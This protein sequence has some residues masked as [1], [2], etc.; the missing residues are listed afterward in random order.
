MKPSEVA[1]LLVV[2]AGL[3]RYASAANQSTDKAVAWAAALNVKASALTFAEARQLVVEH[4]AESDESLTPYA[5][6]EAWNRKHRRLPAQIAADVRSAKARRLIGWDHSPKVPL[7]DHVAA[8]L[9]G[10]RA[11]ENAQAPAIEGAVNVSPLALDVGR[12]P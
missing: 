10:I 9:M 7:P 2:D 3:N 12:R 5:L 11:K 8:A 6:I 4:Y 1:D